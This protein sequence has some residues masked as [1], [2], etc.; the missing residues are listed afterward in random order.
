MINSAINAVLSGWTLQH[1]ANLASVLSVAAIAIAWATYVRTH[2]KER[3]SH[4]NTMFREYLRLDFEY[5]MVPSK[6]REDEALRRLRA[7]KMWVLDEINEWVDG[8]ER[9]R[10][11]RK[12]AKEARDR[13]VRNWKATIQYHLHRHSCPGY[14]DAF[15]VSEAC[16]SDSFV[17]FAKK[18]HM[19][20]PDHRRCPFCEEM[21]KSALPAPNG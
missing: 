18:W 5:H 11:F 10:L 19:D 21:N 3:K 13:L 16:Y 4:V 9:K 6:Q 17:A 7:Y 8:E 2:R 14:W 1:F 12:S 15:L 20:S